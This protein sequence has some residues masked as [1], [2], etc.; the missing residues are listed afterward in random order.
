MPEVATCFM[1]R[2]KDSVSF[3]A[4]SQCSIDR[5]TKMTRYLQA[6]RGKSWFYQAEPQHKVWMRGWAVESPWSMTSQIKIWVEHCVQ[7]HYEYDLM[8]RAS[9][10]LHWDAF[11]GWGRECSGKKFNNLT[12]S[13][14]KWNSTLP[15][16]NK[17]LDISRTPLDVGHTQPSSL[18]S[19][20]VSRNHIRLHLSFYKT[21]KEISLLICNYLQLSDL[22]RLCAKLSNDYT[23]MDL[24]GHSA[25]RLQPVKG[26]FL[27]SQRGN[28]VAICV[29]LLL[30]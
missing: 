1:D 23:P 21:K 19:I 26:L 5:T 22:R 8:L 4:W 29:I 30:F 10:L 6:F 2:K 11:T 28:G 27:L 20:T 25:K 7:Y 15:I 12:T 16:L 24:H 9:S 13:R 3:L 14:T 17:I 18:H